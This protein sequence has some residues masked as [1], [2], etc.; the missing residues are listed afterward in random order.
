MTILISTLYS[1]Q[2]EIEPIRS[3]RLSRR[4]VPDPPCGG[5]YMFS[6]IGRQ[7]TVIAHAGRLRSLSACANAL[8][9][10]RI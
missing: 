6:V 9:D 10:F 3:Y 1:I 5:Y 2:N 4:T 7:T 8:A